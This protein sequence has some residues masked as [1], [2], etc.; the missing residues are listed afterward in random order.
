[1]HGGCKQLEVTAAQ[2]LSKEI[3]TVYLW[4]INKHIKNRKMYFIELL[5]T[6]TR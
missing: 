3:S 2:N 4:D 6:E 1:M 5:R